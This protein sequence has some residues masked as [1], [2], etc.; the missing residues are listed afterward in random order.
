MILSD[1]PLEA[2]VLLGAARLA[3][4]IPDKT[5]GENLL[6]KIASTLPRA[7]YFIADAPADRYGLTPLHFAP[8]PDSV[9]R[10]L[11]NQP[12]IEGHLEYLKSM[13]QED[14]GWPITWKAPGSASICEWRGRWT[15]DAICRLVDYGVISGE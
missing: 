12:Q 15:L 13:Q 10:K 1:P 7:S 11:F 5:T 8:T 14:G 9:F 6:D 2:H 3:E 4:F